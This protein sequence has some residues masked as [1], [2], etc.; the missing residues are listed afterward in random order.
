MDGIG[1]CYTF[2]GKE[3]PATGNVHPHW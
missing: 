2:W 1:V 3:Q